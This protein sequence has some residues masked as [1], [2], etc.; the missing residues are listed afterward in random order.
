M[1]VPIKQISGRLLGDRTFTELSTDARSLYLLMI[2]RGYH[3]GLI[4]Q[5][6][7]VAPFGAG[8]VDAAADQLL[9]A[10]FLVHLSGGVLA[11]P[12]ARLEVDLAEVAA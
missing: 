11:I 12:S 9:R 3:H 1:R 8:R 10:G 5:L 2:S 6:D 4:E 7:E